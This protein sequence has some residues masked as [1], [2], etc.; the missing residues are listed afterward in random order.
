MLGK[1]VGN[2]VGRPVLLGLA[3]C[4]AFTVMR[5]GGN[6]SVQCSSN[7]G[8]CEMA[9]MPTRLGVNNRITVDKA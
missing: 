4:L 8:L 6:T 2:V 1:R 3:S 5:M 7:A 9:S